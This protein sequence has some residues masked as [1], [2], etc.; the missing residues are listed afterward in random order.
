MGV[1]PRL[2]RGAAA[3][4][5]LYSGGRLQARRETTIAHRE[6]ALASPALNFCESSELG[7]WNFRLNWQNRVIPPRF[8]LPNSFGTSATHAGL[9]VG[10]LEWRVFPDV[11]SDFQ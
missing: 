4:G 9:F 3:S 5:L 2:G 1:H 7:T 11:V 10:R 6:R 8:A